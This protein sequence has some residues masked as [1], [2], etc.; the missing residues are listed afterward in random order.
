VPRLIFL[1]TVVQAAMVVAGS[2]IAGHLSDRMGRRKA[3]VMAGSAIQGLGLWLIAGTHS[4]AMLLPGVCL[5]GMG[6][7]IYEG[8][9]LALVT[10]VLPDRDHHAAKDLGLLNIANTL[11]QVAAPLIAPL[12]LTVGPGG[13]LL[14]FVIAGTLAMLGSACIAPLK[15][16]R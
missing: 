9:D 6:H 2:L 10:D 7:G 1:S 15:S 16:V 11:P 5:V 3:F 12:I 14:L 13:Y 4:Y 8:V